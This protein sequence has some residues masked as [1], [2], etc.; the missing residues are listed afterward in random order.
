MSNSDFEECVAAFVRRDYPRSG[1]L[2]LNLLKTG[3][4]PGLTHILLT[5]MRRMGLVRDVIAVASPL[6]AEASDDPWRVTLLRLLLGEREPADVLE[7]APDDMSRCQ[8]LCF[9]GSHL[10][11]RGKVHEALDALQESRAMNVDCF[12]QRIASMETEMVS[13]WVTSLQDPDDE[14]DRLR[15]VFASLRSDGHHE[16]SVHIAHLA[17]SIALAHHGEFDPGTG[18]R[19]NELAMAYLDAKLYERAE[20]LFTQALK[21]IGV[22]DGVSSETYAIVVSNLA[23][24]NL[25]QGK[26]A[27]SEELYRIAVDICALATGREHPTYATCLGGLAVVCRKLGKH[28]EAERLYL[29][30]LDVRKLAFG[31]DDARYVGILDG[32]IQLY[33][34]AGNLAQAEARIHE[35]VEVVGRCVGRES[36]AFGSRLKQLAALYH[37]L[38]RHSE[39]VAASNESLLIDV[40][41]FGWE[42]P[43]SIGTLTSHSLLLKAAGRFADA[44][45]G[46]QVALMTQIKLLGDTHPDV[47]ETTQSFG[48]LYLDCSQPILG[49]MYLSRALEM[50]RALNG[51]DSVEF[52]WALR[53]IAE[54]DWF[55]GRREDAE[56]ML[57]QALNTIER[58]VGTRDLR[59]AAC[60]ES[61]AF[62]CSGLGRFDEAGVLLDRSLISKEQV[63]GKQNPSVGLTVCRVGLHRAM[64]GKWSEAE[65]H[66]RLGTRM[67]ELNPQ[68]TRNPEYAHMLTSLGSVLVALGRHSE[69]F[70]VLLTGERWRD[71]LIQEGLTA[72]GF[73]GFAIEPPIELLGL[74][75]NVEFQT[76]ARIRDLLSVV[77]RR[78]GI[79]A[80]AEAAQKRAEM[81]TRSDHA[82]QEAADALAPAFKA[83][84]VAP[85]Q[86]AG[87]IESAQTKLQKSL[88][89]Q[90]SHAQRQWL[91]VAISQWPVQGEM[92]RQ[93]WLERLHAH[94]SDMGRM[95]GE[96]DRLDEAVRLSLPSGWLMQSFEHVSVENVVSLLP[97]RSA[98]VE[99]LRVP[100]HDAAAIR[101]YG[102]TNRGRPHYYAFVVRSGAPEELR[103]IDLGDAEVIEK[104]LHLLRSLVSGE[105]SGRHLHAGNAV[106]T[107]RLEMADAA[108]VLRAAVFDPILDALDGRKRL[109]VAPDGQLWTLPFEILPAGKD[110]HVLDEYEITYVATGR[111]LLT[112]SDHAEA[113]S[114]RPVV[115][116]DPDY[117]LVENQP[118][119]TDDD[120]SST[121][122]SSNDMRAQE[123]DREER[124][125]RSGLRFT[126]LPGTRTEGESVAHLLDAAVLVGADALEGRL[127]QLRSP[128]VLHIATHGYFL[129]DSPDGDLT[130]ERGDRTMRPFPTPLLN[131]GVALAGA[132]TWLRRGRLPVAAEDGL[133]TAAD[134]ATMDLSGTALVVLSACETGLGEIAIGQGVYGLRRSASLAGARSLIM[135]LWKVPDRETDELMEGFYRRLRSGDTRS[136]ALRQAQL[137]IKAR[138]HNPFFW[139][140]F[141]CQGDW[142]AVPA[143]QTFPPH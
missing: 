113:V 78:K 1:V 140:A 109:V 55:E 74:L 90:L 92:D 54:L 81:R 97:D 93:E 99:F 13:D 131:S 96:R 137:D 91:D 76:P 36:P 58:T 69:A 42:H 127:K 100:T 87:W 68:H 50:W 80:D 32:L 16:Q 119:N 103:F 2:A 45:S 63:L 60:C 14:L 116:A 71:A 141:I 28:A 106:A 110:R 24:L 79:V 26:L 25:N 10:L 94:V 82:G 89:E 130:R 139:G 64:R 44:I 88:V 143:L 125:R 5:S 38:G 70:D 112:R 12:E 126:P 15:R 105:N 6:L 30:A 102:H 65:E 48:Q 7:E 49:R 33:E 133:L 37:R 83:G 62:C 27:E 86:L 59:F 3:S 135:S 11:T 47:A 17:L 23:L 41:Q 34:D 72:V 132:N 43:Q 142:G 128:L 115:V 108:A 134:L 31:T 52:A 118:H 75:A 77:W 8:A 129:E 19:L 67:L 122:Q 22:F 98:L 124:V 20:P 84:D 40:G 66:L 120:P 121:E 104:Q 21:L 117:D 73:Q 35:A 18:H 9:A 56:P 53:A 57:R 51:E 95:L 4:N 101:E 29:E 85:E 61:L 136:N 39:A 107:D 111:D 123:Q 114:N 138:K 46:Y